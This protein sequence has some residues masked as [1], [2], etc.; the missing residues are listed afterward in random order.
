MV[1]WVAFFGQEDE[2]WEYSDSCMHSACFLAWEHREAFE[3]LYKYQP[4]VD[5]DDLQLKSM[6]EEYGMP[7]WLKKIK[8]Y[9]ADHQPQD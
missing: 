1:C 7:D 5:F 4:R 2:L 6:I 9:R 8:E 3:K